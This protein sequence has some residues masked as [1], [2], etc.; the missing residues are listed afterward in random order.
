MKEGEGAY[1]VEP[2]F[3]YRV[4]CY[5][6]GQYSFYEN[7]QDLEKGSI[8]YVTGIAYTIMEKVRYG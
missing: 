6:D 4:Y 1:M 3:T 2:K 5:G 8:V 7:S